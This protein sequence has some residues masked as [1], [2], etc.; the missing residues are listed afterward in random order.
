[1]KDSY[2]VNIESYSYTLMA[3][4]G[5]VCYTCMKLFVLQ[6]FINVLMEESGKT[7]KQNTKVLY[8]IATVK[9]VILKIMK[10]EVVYEI[11]IHV[12]TA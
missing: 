7:Q 8:Y 3:L 12:V 6:S 11:Y 9:N 10:L 1:M 4:L 5:M 2:N